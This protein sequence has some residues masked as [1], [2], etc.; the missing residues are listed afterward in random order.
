MSWHIFTALY[1]TC[2][3]LHLID[4]PSLHLVSFH[5][6]YHHFKCYVMSSEVNWTE[7]NWSDLKRSEGMSN[8]LQRSHVMPNKAVSNE[9][10]S[11]KTTNNF[12]DSVTKETSVPFMPLTMNSIWTVIDTSVKTNRIWWPI[13]VSPLVSFW[14]KLKHLLFKLLSLLLSH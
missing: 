1:F 2:T 9:I 13:S 12:K 7:I 10:I 5:L 6:I 3:V 8:Q 11:F 14:K 4:M